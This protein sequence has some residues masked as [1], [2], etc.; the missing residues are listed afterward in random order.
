MTGVRE[1]VLADS[2]GFCFGVRRAVQMVNDC[3]EKDPKPIY[4]LG[5][6][7]HNEY[8][9]RDMEARGVTTLADEQ[10]LAGVREGTVVLRSH[11]VSRAV[12]EDLQAR[13][14]RIADATCPFVKK[15]HEIVARESANGR[16]IVIIGDREHPEVMGT[17][18]W[19][20]SPCTVIS[21]ET[22][23]RGLDLPENT[24]LCVVAQTTFN[25]EKFQDFVEIISGLGYDIIVL[26]TIC[27]A[28][29]MRQEEAGRIADKADIMLVVGSGTSSNTR[30]LYEICTERCENTYYIQSL[31]DLNNIHFQSDSCVGITAGASTPNHIIQEVSRYVRRAEL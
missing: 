2:A 1:V 10:G 9:V 17:M 28:T 12:Y 13:G 31:E 30:K 14:I 20:C 18:G 5:P 11:G 25:L 24:P 21:T 7:I 16:H 27:S 4:T 23:A 8:V 19:S 15:I 22:E 26:N 6:I 29:A 3:I